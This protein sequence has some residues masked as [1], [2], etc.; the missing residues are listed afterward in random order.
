MCILTTLTGSTAAASASSIKDDA[1]KLSAAG[2]LAGIST[3]TVNSAV[4]ITSAGDDSGV[5]FTVTGTDESGATI[6]EKI[7]GG[8]S[9]SSSG[10]K[11]FKTVTKVSADKATASTI[12]VGK[13]AVVSTTED[14]IGDNEIDATTKPTIF[15]NATTAIAVKVSKGYD[16]N[17]DSQSDTFEV[18]GR[19]DGVS[20]K[21]AVSGASNLVL[22][23][24]DAA[25]GSVKCT[26]SKNVKIKSY[27][28]D[29]AVTFTVTGTDDTGAAITETI[30]G[31]NSAEAV[32]T[33]L[34]KTITKIET[35]KSTTGD[36]EVG[37]TSY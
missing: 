6:T 14:R 37:L 15:T 12:D 27:A 9:A 4:T 17:G 36:V 8:N 28:N 10:S 32:G 21:A 25:S 20:L 11:V 3:T 22:T 29:S 7:T 24:A 30:K 26:E 13:A 34:F 16:A 18:A 2:D 33:K 5:T 23:G 31:S 1:T 19:S 35:D